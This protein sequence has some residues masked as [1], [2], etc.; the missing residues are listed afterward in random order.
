MSLDKLFK[1]LGGLV[2]WLQQAGEE[3]L[4]IDRKGELGSAAQDIAKGMYDLHLRVGTLAGHSTDNRGGQPLTPGRPVV[5]EPPF[6][7]FDEPREV[8]I[9]IQLPG[10]AA[11][12]VRLE[13]QGKELILNAGVGER[14]FARRIPLSLAADLDRAS[15]SF[16]NGVLE[17]RLP[18]P[19]AQ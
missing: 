13:A 14:Q 4:E 8:V 12:D 7:L 18:K 15:I 6:D 2:R 3:G 17:I 1:E 19:D 5:L 11:S 10:V 9:I 16:T